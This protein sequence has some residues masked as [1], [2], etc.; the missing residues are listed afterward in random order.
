MLLTLKYCIMKKKIRL[1]ASLC[2]LSFAGVAYAQ[3]DVT[4]LYIVNP[5]FELS[6]EGIPMSGDKQDYSSSSTNLYGWIVPNLGTDKFYN[7][8][9]VSKDG[10][11]ASAFGQPAP[12][13]GQYYYFNRKG[14]GDVNAV[15]SQAEAVTLPSG[16]YYITVDCKAAESHDDGKFRATD[17]GFTVTSSATNEA[18]A[19]K[20]TVVGVNNPGASY[21]NTS[22][23]NTVGMWFDVNEETSVNIAI[24]QTL[25]GTSKRS[26]IC[27]DNVKLYRWSLDDDENYKSASE[28]SPLDVTNKF[29]TNPYFDENTNGWTSTTGAQNKARASNKVGDFVGYFMENWNPTAFS[30]KISQSVTGLPYGKYKI[31]MVGYTETVGENSVSLFVGDLKEYLTSTTPTTVAFDTKVGFDGSLEFGIEAQNNVTKWIGIDNIRMEFLGYGDF[32]DDEATEAQ[33]ELESLVQKAEGLLL[34]P[35]DKETAENLTAIKETVKNYLDGLTGGVDVADYIKYSQLLKNETVSAE[36]SVSYYETISDAMSDNRVVAEQYNASE[37]FDI[38][39]ETIA[40][41]YNA[42]TL[43]S[44]VSEDLVADIRRAMQVAVA[45]SVSNGDISGIINNPSFETGGSVWGYGWTINKNTTGGDWFNFKTDA[46]VPDGARFV[47]MNANQINFIDIC[48]DLVLPEGV[49]TLY[50]DAR[51]SEEPV[52]EKGGTYLMATVGNRQFKS[53]G[54]VKSSDWNKMKVSFIVKGE[55]KVTLG[56]YSRGENLKNNSRGRFQVDNFRL[57]VEDSYAREN[58]Q[59]G[60]FGTIC[61]PFASVVAECEG[62]DKVYKVTEFNQ[63][64]AV[65]TP[66]ESMDAGVPY[67]FKTNADVVTF[68]MSARNV[69]EEPVEDMYLV[70]TFTDID[71]LD[72]GTYVLSDNKFCRVVE[73]NEGDA[74][75]LAAYRCYFKP[76]ANGVKNF[77]FVEDD[78]ETT[79]IDKIESEV[80]MKNAVIYDLTGRRVTSPVK[81]IYIVNGKKMVIDNLK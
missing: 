10:T 46:P 43:S 69:V 74:V 36:N 34:R 13:D 28:D 48:Q 62:V 31:S 68:R 60:Q 35:M 41:A 2:A 16:R 75:T 52:M 44:V 45:S 79:G 80:D 50:A 11:N 59:V 39:I 40:E 64:I 32:S 53:E 33:A 15:L 66:V 14:W 6:A 38:A 12:S 17:V 81:G 70:G 29:V 61:I 24:K 19:S 47:D 26:D 67:I 72:Y 27:L 21:F 37:S 25:K 73:G 23:W 30:G 42:G 49:Y 4:D 71:K 58:L 57:Y 77:G 63:D 7:I 3:D 55:Q 5:S 65:I 22:H 18:I 76:L 9:T 51:T 56:I 54:L 20:S 78:G 1:L 8:Q